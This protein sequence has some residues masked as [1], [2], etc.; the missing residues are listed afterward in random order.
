MGQQ[1][2]MKKKTKSPAA[3]VEQNAA[4]PGGGAETP[5][6]RHSDEEL[7]GSGHE[8]YLGDCPICILPLPLDQTHRSI[9]TC[10]MKEICKGCSL[11]S[12][13]A[14][15]KAGREEI[16]CAFCRAPVPEE[17]PDGNEVS[18]A[19]VKKRVEVG[20][21]SAMGMMGQCHIRGM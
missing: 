7:F 21:A 1:K 11:A 8:S 5:T 2:R 14:D 12:E 3:K 18:V 10:C 4:G 19:Q 9:M 17:G 16:V 20:D 13:K 15:A 6:K